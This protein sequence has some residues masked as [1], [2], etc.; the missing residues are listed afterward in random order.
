MERAKELGYQIRLNFILVDDVELSL[1]RIANRVQNGGHGIPE[2]VVRQRHA[3]QLTN[4]E[5]ALP[6]TDIAVFFDNS[7][8]LRVIGLHT[9][10]TPLEFIEEDSQIVRS[11]IEKMKNTKSSEPPQM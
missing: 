2:S 7:E 1:E 11:L 6:L 5:R 9:K 8:Y 3:K 4:M 10:D